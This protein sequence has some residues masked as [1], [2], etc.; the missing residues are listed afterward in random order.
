MALTVSALTLTLPNP[1]RV[2]TTI[3][4]AYE[5][6]GGGET[7]R[8]SS[9]L[10]YE[11]VIS[12]REGGYRVSRRTLEFR[13]TAQAEVPDLVQAIADALPARD[14]TYLADRNLTPQSVENWSELSARVSNDMVSAASDGHM[15]SGLVVRMSLW[16]TTSPADA[17]YYALRSEVELARPIGAV[18]KAGK[19]IVTDEPRAFLFDGQDIA[20]RSV[21]SLEKVDEARGIAVLSYRRAADPKALKAILDDVFD[22]IVSEMKLAG[23][24]PVDAKKLT[25]PEFEDTTTCRYEVDLKTG[26]PTKAECEYTA[27][28]TD[29]EFLQVTTRTERW[30]IT[31]TLKN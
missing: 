16:A 30:A 14:L 27:R 9:R 15:D 10:R 25:A 26:L 31:Q 20:G 8:K 29:L 18:F 24:G 5:Q 4:Y 28:R 6:V 2:E 1:A 17:V 19:S 12:A 22:D 7:E 11:K 21:L 23:R 3:D 13:P